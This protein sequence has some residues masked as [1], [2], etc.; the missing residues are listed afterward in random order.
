MAT[1]KDP[2]AYIQSLRDNV[3]S[4]ENWPVMWPE[5]IEKVVNEIKVIMLAV[6]TYLTSDEDVTATNKLCEISGELYQ[7]LQLANRKLQTRKRQLEYGLEELSSTTSANKA[8]LSIDVAY[9]TFHYDI[10]PL[11]VIRELLVDLP[12]N[13][14]P[15]TY[16]QRFH[17]SSI[18]S[19]APVPNQAITEISL[20]CIPFSRADNCIMVFY[21]ERSPLS[22]S[23]T[24]IALRIATALL[25]LDAVVEVAFAGSS[26]T[27]LGKLASGHKAFHFTA[28]GGKHHLAAI[29]RNFI[30]YQLYLCNV[31]SVTAFFFVGVLGFI[32]L[33][34]RNLTQYRTGWF[35]K[36]SRYSYYT[37]VIMVGPSLVLTTAALAC[38]FTEASHE[39]GHHI[40]T[41]LAIKLNGSPYNRGTWTPQSWFS[42]VLELQLLRDR[43]DIVKHLTL[44]EGWKY[45]LIDLFVLQFFH[46]LIT[47]ADLMRWIQKPR[48]PETWSR[49]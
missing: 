9:I 22:P 38:V 20:V 11:V 19:L 49:F 10:K 25:L 3:P 46:F 5:E 29:P 32:S 28:F 7:D 41:A 39:T 35:A 1:D 15:P 45:N 42:A 31:A 8:T 33:W 21:G 13:L 26:L 17:S 2:V 16:P 43:E 48:H 14:A 27:W 36:F 37:W 6:S 47:V 34:L 4:L 12:H 30:G 23:F 24:S 44:M 18:E 40:D